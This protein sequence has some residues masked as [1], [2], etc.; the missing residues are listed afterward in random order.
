[1]S[2]TSEHRK[3]RHSSSS[4]W[5]LDPKYLKSEICN[6][7]LFCPAFFIEDYETLK[8]NNQNRSV[9]TE[10]AILKTQ[11]KAAIAELA[12]TKNSLKT[13]EACDGHGKK[14]HLLLF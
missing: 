13:V 5:L 11:L 7:V 3:Q 1:M 10:N 2:S 12:Q 8:R 9:D 4:T 6:V 14:S